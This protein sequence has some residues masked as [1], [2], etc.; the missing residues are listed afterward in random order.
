VVEGYACN[1]SEP[2]EARFTVDT[3]PPEI[4]IVAPEEGHFTNQVALAIAGEVNEA[5]NLTINDTF[6][7]LDLARRFDH[8]IP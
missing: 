7:R 2:A 6:I 3:T 5:A 8:A 4:T 1:V